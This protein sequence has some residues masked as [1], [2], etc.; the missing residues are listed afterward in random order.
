MWG[1]MLMRRRAWTMDEELYLEMEFGKYSSNTLAKNLN[2]SIS[3]VNSKASKMGLRA[4][5][6]QEWLTVTDFCKF[7]NIPRT[8]IEFWIKTTDFPTTRVHKYRRVYP[9]KFWSW[10][11][12]N[13][14]RIDWVNFPQHRLGK[15]PTWVSVARKANRTHAARKRLWTDEELREL[16]YLLEQNKYTYP[17]LCEML[18]RTHG[19]IKRK[20]YDLNLP[21]AVYLDR[22]P[23]SAKEYTEEELEEIVSMYREGIPMIKISRHFGRSE[24]GVRDKLGRS[25]YRF[26]SRQLIKA[27]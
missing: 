20:I 27:N 17:E 26:E 5:D 11:D 18:N 1:E 21:W 12:E 19:A 4:L 13:K 16:E 22:H 14:H 24:A 9:D 10:A 6:N 7:T 3:S 25:G 15:E 23:G 8:T 2:R